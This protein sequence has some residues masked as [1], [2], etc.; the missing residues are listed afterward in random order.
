MRKS[1]G[2]LLYRFKNTAVE[3]FLVHHGG[4]FWQNKDAGAWSITKGEFT[5]EEQ[6]LDAALREFKEETGVQLSG[7]FI[8]LTPV[9]QKGG[10]LV[11]AWA[12]E[13]DI[14]PDEIKC[15][16]FKIEWPPRSGQWKTYPEVD[17]GAWFSVEE[18]KQKINASQIAFID[19]LLEILQKKGKGS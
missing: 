19:E 18:A 15:N 3:F 5:E 16:T 9:K 14:N 10:K 6:P 12:L 2:I 1:A 8:A 4:P 11:Y 13:G 17:K 7:D